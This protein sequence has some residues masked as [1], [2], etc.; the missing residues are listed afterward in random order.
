MTVTHP[1]LLEKAIR[2]QTTFITRIEMSLCAIAWG[3]EST[4]QQ[5]QFVTRRIRADYKRRVQKK[6][7]A[8]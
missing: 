6:G 3:V 7:R 4:E 8:A 2:S 1:R 5:Y